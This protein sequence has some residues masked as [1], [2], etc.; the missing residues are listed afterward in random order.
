MVLYIEDIGKV[1][2]EGTLSIYCKNMT[3]DHVNWACV[4]YLALFHIPMFAEINL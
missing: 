3:T 2:K 4:C 1:V